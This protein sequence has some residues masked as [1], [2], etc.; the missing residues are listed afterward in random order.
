MKTIM[1]IVAAMTVMAAAPVWAQRIGE[2]RVPLVQDDSPDPDVQAEFK[3]LRARGTEPLNLH[4]VY[5]NAP[6]LARAVSAL[7]QALRYGA[8]VPRA[9]RELI[10]LRAA[11]LAHGDYQFGEHRPLAISCGIS[12]AQ[13]DSLPQWRASNL[14]NDRQRAVLSYA[15]AMVSADGVD[16]ATFDAMKAFFSTQE[17]V[18]LTMNA[19][20]YGASSQIG[21]ALRITA[22]GN[23][24]KSAYGTCK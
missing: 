17:I 12:G 10:I 2:A 24:E 20:Y 11:Q 22:A 13:I 23:P 21:R 8:V 3:E 1:G 14:F 6:K 4:R 16:D 15:D 18:E 19:A 7:A 5:N 9:D